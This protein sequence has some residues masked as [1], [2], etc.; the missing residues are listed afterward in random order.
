MAG[1]RDIDELQVAIIHDWLIS[2]RGSERVLQEFSK[3]FPS[4]VLFAS[5]LDKHKLPEELRNRDIRTTWIQKLPNAVKWYQKYLFLMP[6]AY[7]SLDLSGFDLVISS[8]HSCAKGV[9][10]AK[11]AVHIC[12]C[13]TPM[14]YAWSG[15]E[16]Y[17]N[18]L[19]S[20]LAKLLMTFLMFW[21]R[22]WDLS[23]NKRVDR[24]IAIS[25][26][27]QRRIERY[28]C[29]DSVVIFPGISVE[30]Q[31]SYLAMS[32]VAPFLMGRSYYLSLGRLVSY[33]RVDLA[34]AA[35]NLLHRTLI[36]AGTGPELS[37]LQEIAGPSIFFIEE[38]TD[39]E[40]ATLYLHCDALIFPG[41]EDFGL[42]VVEAQVHGSPVI[43]YGHGGVE[44]TVIDRMTGVFFHEQSASSL[45][46]AIEISEQISYDKDR[47]KQHARSFSNEHFRSH[48]VEYIESQLNL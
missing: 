29:R 12:Y 15:F 9:K 27:V 2:F 34:I 11:G 25:H 3:V 18:T 44:D 30:E 6:F 20:G 35:C 40:A 28:Y 33:K 26:E 14:R 19:H 41:E 42:T 22:K 17:R 16:E 1:Q 21:M 8:S 4:A 13:Y 46:H 31:P 5:V 47:I 24:F 10:P 43:A 7:E 23:V 48:I 36:V 39:E 37:R 32:A 38:F 45:A